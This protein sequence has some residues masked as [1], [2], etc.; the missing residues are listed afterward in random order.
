MLISRVSV[1]SGS[2][3]LLPR[4]DCIIW[5]QPHIQ[6]RE[7]GSKKGGSWSGL[8]EQLR[9]QNVS[10]WTR[11]LP[12]G[13][14]FINCSLE[15][16]CRA[17]SPAAVKIIHYFLFLYISYYKMEQGIG[18]ISRS[19]KKPTLW[20]CSL[21]QVLPPKLSAQG[22]SLLPFNSTAKLSNLVRAGM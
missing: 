16:V 10:A 9:E 20:F 14:E 7:T 22:Q 15:R 4:V 8:W 19:S 17:G 3:S 21:L 6:A 13:N 5:W 12:S 18:G 11:M 2:K 1:L